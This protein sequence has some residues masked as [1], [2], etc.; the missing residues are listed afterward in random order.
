ML[1]AAHCIAEAELV[2]VLVRL[3]EHDERTYI[4]CE[5]TRCAP[6]PQD[7][8]PTVITYHSG[9][10]KNDI[11]NDIALVKLDHAAKINRKYIFN[12]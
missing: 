11:A 5:G 7:F 8:R 12:E 10:K 3:G 6:P 2:L 4:D 9:Y 1:T